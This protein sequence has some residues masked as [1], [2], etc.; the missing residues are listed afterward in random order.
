[1]K[2][3]NGTWLNWIYDWRSE[4]DWMLW[5]K[6]IALTFDEWDWENAETK[7]CDLSCKWKP[8]VDFLSEFIQMLRHFL[9]EWNVQRLLSF[10]A[11]N[12][13]SFN[14]KDFICQI[15]F[16]IFLN[17]K[18]RQ[19]Y[20]YLVVILWTFKIEFQNCLPRIHKIS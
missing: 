14:C 15:K 6:S 3:I 11:W 5:L 20:T 8:F 7:L 17:S 4:E 18:S 12:P 19:W 2:T 10:F 1:M 9:F 16:S 13:F